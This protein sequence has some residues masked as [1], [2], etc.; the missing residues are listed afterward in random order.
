[1]HFQNTIRHG[2]ITE[3]LDNLSSTLGEKQIEKHKEDTRNR[4]IYITLGVV[5]ALINMILLIFY[6]LFISLG[7]GFNN[8]FK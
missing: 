4:V 5:I 6:P 8:I 3:I 1:M 7:Q 2:N